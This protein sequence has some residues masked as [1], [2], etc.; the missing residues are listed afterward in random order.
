MIP[1]F[2]IGGGWRFEGFRL[3]FA[4]FVEAA[5]S[6]TG[7][8]IMLVVADEADGQLDE[9]LAKY[10]TIFEGLG[11]APE[12]LA[13]EV[14]SESAHLTRAAVETQ[15]PTGLFVCGG[16][17]PLYHRALVA[18]RA[19]IAYIIEQ[20][21][22]YGGFSAGAMIAPEQAILGGWRIERGGRMIPILG[23]DFSEDLDRL[24]VQAGLG[25]APFAVDVHASQWGNLTRPLHAVALGLTREGWAI[26]EDTMLEIRDDEVRVHGLGHAYQML[27][28]QDGGVAVTLHPAGA[29]VPLQ[30]R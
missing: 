17:T 24:E 21:V 5:A 23:Q 16:L 12:D 30:R 6:P 4:R 13:I 10:R 22:A 28:G 7:H 29:R 26:D 1:I 11:V 15:R 25:L 9:Q 18:D 2:L 20:G 14:V 27:P 19:W 3:T 8:K